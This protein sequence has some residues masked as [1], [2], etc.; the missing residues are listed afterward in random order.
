MLERKLQRVTCWRFR[1]TNTYRLKTWFLATLGVSLSHVIQNW[2]SSNQIYSVK[3]LCQ[4]CRKLCKAFSTQM[5]VHLIASCSHQ[6]S[7]CEFLNAE[8]SWSWRSGRQK[9]QKLVSWFGLVHTQILVSF[10][11]RKYTNSVTLTAQKV[12][13]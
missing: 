4:S 9:Y 11:C 12:Q 8:L 7:S 3:S 2:Y 13:L 10:V 5:N 1:L 6:Q